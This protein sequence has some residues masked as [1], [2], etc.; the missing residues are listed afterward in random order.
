MLY[1]DLRGGSAT[2]VKKYITRLIENQVYDAA[3]GVGGDRREHHIKWVKNNNPDG[4]I[5]K[6][7]LL[8]GGRNVNAVLH[9]PFIYYP[10]GFQGISVVTVHD[11]IPL[12]VKGHSRFRKRVRF[13]LKMKY[14]LKKADHIIAVS[15]CTKRDIQRI[16]SVP[17]D[18][19]TVIPNGVDD[20]F[21]P[22]SQCETAYIYVKYH[23]PKDVKIIL[24]VGNKQYHKNLKRAIEAFA[25]LK[26]VA[27]YRMYIVGSNSSEYDDIDKFIISHNLSTLVREIGYINDIDLRAFYNI[28][29]VFL[30]PS[31]Y[32]GFGIP[33]LEA[34]KCGT[35]VICSRTSS[36]PEVVGNAAI[37]V[38]PYSVQQM[39]AAL[40]R[41]LASDEVK[42]NYIQKGH[43]Q[44]KK[45][46]WRNTSKQTKALLENVLSKKMNEK[47][48]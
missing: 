48:K 24:T 16:F 18:K 2:G 47:S 33:P 25:N 13:K 38:N 6:N 15:R 29:D 34:M 31:L 9:C 19:I 12:M 17:E 21:Q 8:L 20:F 23:I 22:L 45:F 4:A 27:Q 14:M 7:R 1:I 46:T 36:L 39:T 37:L 3:I 40:E 43:E 26:N 28:A 5:L 42:N 10:I 30:F 32:E 35:P 41:V 11:L 44:V